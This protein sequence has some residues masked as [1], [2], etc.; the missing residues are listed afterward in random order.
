MKKVAIIQARMD[1][2]RLPNKVLVDIE[3]KPML[4]HVAKRVSSSKLLD[5]II[6]ATSK[7]VN[8]NKIVQF[9]K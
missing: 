2:T 3:G 6:I 8:D 7:Q 4:W 1:S 5:E 9:A